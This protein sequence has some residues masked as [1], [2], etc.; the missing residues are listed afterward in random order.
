V[1]SSEH[2]TSVERLAFS[3]TQ[4]M[5][6]VSIKNST[7]TQLITGKNADVEL[8]KDHR[9]LTGSERRGRA[10]AA[11]IR[12]SETRRRSNCADRRR[13]MGLFQTPTRRHGS[14]LRRSSEARD[15]EGIQGCYCGP[16]LLRSSGQCCRG[17][18]HRSY[19]LRPGVQSADK[20]RP[21]MVADWRLKTNSEEWSSSAEKRG[22]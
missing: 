15:A 16:A 12:R 10:G 9:G 20:E 13:D 11:Q 2:P 5:G 19:G 18:A 8:N 6:F 7:H 3:S 22:R 1:H 17:Q 4:N 21:D 14:G